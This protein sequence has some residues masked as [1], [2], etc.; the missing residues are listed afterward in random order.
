MLAR[1]MCRTAP[2][3]CVGLLAVAT[4]AGAASKRLVAF[5]F[6]QTLDVLLRIEDLNGDGDTL[7]AGEVS[8]FIDDTIAA[9]LGVENAQGMHAFSR[10]HV[11]ATDNFVPDNI[12]RL[13]DAN[14]DGDAFDAGEA[15]VY[16]DGA[17]PGGFSLTNPASLTRGDDGAFYVI[18]NNTLD[19]AN[20]EA[21]YRLADNNSDG[22]V[23]D[24]NEVT[25]VYEF[26]PAGVSAT[27]V[28]EVESGAGGAFYAFDITSA[29]TRIIRV[30]PDGSAAT[31]WVTASTMFSLS[32]VSLSGTIAELGFD[33][34]R[35]RMLVG[36][37]LGANVVICSLR[38][39]N[40]NNVI[41]QANEVRVVWNEGTSGFNTGSPRDIF[42]LPDNTVLWVD[43]LS[44]RIWR[45]TDLN[46][47]GDYADA[48]E[49]DFIYDAAAAGAAGQPSAPLML[50][51]VA[52]LHCVSDLDED[53]VVTL[54]DLS[55]LL[56]NFG[57]V[58]GATPSDGDLDGDGD[59]DL[60]DLSLLLA[61]F[62]ESCAE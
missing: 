42:W 58:S 14:D 45:L 60:T 46:D 16:H 31:D 38:D 47:D 26:S 12:V 2:F 56:A 28:L 4:A 21:L 43:A 15:T 6:D 49:T 59:V 30:E 40:D 17:L 33:R 1:G 54:T 44:D 35:E 25:Q 61:D 55:I 34:Q 24:P 3:L 11:L 27:T 32:S 37:F 52:V 9:T 13:L 39:R 18:D 20:P 48:G 53:G 10:R 29:N 36:G 19:N 8:R 51:V 5:T 57:T 7:D 41:D 62:G 22:D 50:T 23:N